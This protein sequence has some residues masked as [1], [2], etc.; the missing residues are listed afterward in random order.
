M[1]RVKICGITEIEHALI[2]SE[3]GTDFLGLVFAQSRRRVSQ[4]KALQIVEAIHKQKKHPSMVG[5]FVNMPAEEVNRITE[6]CQLDLVQLSGDEDWRYCQQI[7]RPVIKVIHIKKNYTA[8]NII[9]GIESGYILSLKQKPICLLDTMI[10][11][12][13]GGTG[14]TFNW[15]LA[16]EVSA[17]FPVIIAGGLAPENVAKLVREVKPW[18]VDVSTGVETDGRKDAVKIKNFIKAVRRCHI[19]T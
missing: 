6:Y 13:Y 7:E 11:D 12:A 8:K 2:A 16:A 9:S 14:Q 15:Q 5:V 1:I 3:A 19:A 4:E 18:G 17:R 10:E